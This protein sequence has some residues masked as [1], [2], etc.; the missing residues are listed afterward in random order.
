MVSQPMIDLT[1]KVHGKTCPVD[2]GFS[3]YSAICRVLPLFHQPTPTG[4]RLLR[5]RYFGNGLLDI[6]PQSQLVL[7]VPLELVPSCINIAGK[8]LDVDGHQ[9]RIGVPHSKSLVPATALY[10]HL[11]TTRN[12]QDQERFEAEIS[13]QLAGMECR[14]KFS[15]GRR[16]TFKIH[17]R[18]VVGYAVV[19]SELTADES[20]RLQES[21]LGGRR[22]MGCGFFEPWRD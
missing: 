17:N 22:K 20:I 7:R 9:I 15:L 5:G 13:R 10:A 4:V 14:G 8:E 21:G 2:H 16:R 19:V 6:S 3:L 1:F 11:V 18:Q 12:G